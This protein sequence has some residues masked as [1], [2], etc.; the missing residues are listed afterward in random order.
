[1]RST[2]LYKLLHH[3]PEDT[4]KQFA[5]FVASP[6]FNP[7]PRLAKL[8]EI[9]AQHLLCY[10]VRNLTEQET[11][12]L[13]IPGQPFDQN[14]L[15]KDSSALVKLLMQFLA[16]QQ[17]EQ[18]AHLQGYFT[19]KGL[20]QLET[21]AFFQR[22][23][24][25][26]DAEIAQDASPRADLHETKVRM[27]LLRYHYDLRQPRRDSDVDIDGLI[28]Q[29]E[30]S[31]L[32]R[33]MEL[34]YMQLNH[35]L[36]TGKGML[37]NDA[38][39]L[40]EVAEHLTQL[41]PKTQMYFHL[42]RCTLVPALEEAYI[43]FK[44]LLTAS[45]LDRDGQDEMY[46]AALNY[47]ARQLNAGQQKYLRETY[48]LYHE[49]LGK[50]QAGAAPALLSSHFKNIVV[51]ASR[52]G[53]FAWARQFVAQYVPH[54]QGEFNHNAY[55][56]SLGYI[57]F[58]EGHFAQA[59]SYLYRV[60]HDYEDIF[61]GVDARVTLLRIHYETEN[62]IGLDSL[63]DAFRM[64]IQ[65]STHLNGQRKA[66]LQAFIRQLKRLAHIPTFDQA[67]L[68]KLHAEIIGGREMVNK[69]WLLTKLEQNF[70]NL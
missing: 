20:H 30:L 7:V 64:Y 23:W 19:L 11:F 40:A 13:L 47:C 53:E 36:V 4:R 2:K 63:A 17:F 62:M 39:F 15:R 66:N 9:L 22:Y 58:M 31:H 5:L 57:A 6:Y 37:R 14:R 65:R 41:P 8:L 42:H 35:R 54:L 3:V 50:Q 12:A 10:K 33:K 56:F 27:G 59:E 70:Q 67:A 1:M 32:I 61:F 69:Q 43:A 16:Q 48:D 34:C 68:K 49:L 24:E 60:L 25:Q 51:V 29:Q 45:V 55:H 44:A 52:L 28:A 26:V 46:T 21:D 38:P 18:A